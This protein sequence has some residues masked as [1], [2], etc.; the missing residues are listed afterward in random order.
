MKLFKAI[1]EENYLRI[2]KYVYIMTRDKA[3]SE[4]ITQDVFL[5]AYEKGE[6]FLN[7]PAPEGF[8]CKTAKFLTYG[9]VRKA[10]REKNEPLGEDLASKDQD[11]YDVLTADKIE[12]FDEYQMAEDIIRKLNPNEQDLYRRYYIDH[13]PMKEIA[14]DLGIKESALRMRYLRLRETVRKIVSELQLDEI[15]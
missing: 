15:I 7:H 2:Y 3:L 11:V 9:A 14:R 8:L 5:K 13:S 6:E 4:D 1:C 10:G 12:D